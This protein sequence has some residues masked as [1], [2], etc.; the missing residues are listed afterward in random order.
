MRRVNSARPKGE[1]MNKVVFDAATP[2]G[3]VRAVFSPSG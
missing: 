3:A 1:Q 2:A